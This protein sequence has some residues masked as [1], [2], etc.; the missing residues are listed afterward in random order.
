MLVTGFIGTVLWVGRAGPRLLRGLPTMSLTESRN[1]LGSIHSVSMSTSETLNSPKDELC[2]RQIN[3]LCAELLWEPP[4]ASSFVACLD[5][6][7][8]LL[9]VELMT[10]GPQHCTTGWGI[11]VWVC[12]PCWP[13]QGPP[14]KHTASLI[15]WPRRELLR[16]DPTRGLCSLVQKTEH[17]LKEI[18]FP[19]GAKTNCVRS[20]NGPS[21]T[22]LGC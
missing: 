20:L 16:R 12:S 11:P 4:A 14:I 6:T 15:S 8:I 22:A 3:L 10:S 9:P 13:R 2:G 18:V 1:P 17:D 7:H 5:S 21:D 19:S